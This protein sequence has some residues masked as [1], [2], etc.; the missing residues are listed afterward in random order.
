M[1]LRNVL[2]LGLSLGIGCSAFAADPPK[3]A[4]KKKEMPTFLTVEDAGPDYKIQGEYGAAEAGKA[5]FGVQVIALA[6]DRFRA[7]VYPGGLPGAGWGGDKSTKTEIDGKRAGDMVEFDGKGWRA[8]IGADGSSIKLTGQNGEATEL[9]KVMRQSPTMGAKPPEGAK[10]LYASPDDVQKWNNGHAEARGL[11]AAGAVS[12][13]K[14]KDCTLHVEFLLPFRPA[15][16]GQERGNSGVYLQDRYECQVLDSFGLKGENNEC[17]GF[18]QQFA[19]SVNM[20]LPPLQWQTYDIDF[21]AAK[22]DEQGNKTAKAVAT[23]RHNGVVV[24]DH[25]ELAKPT[26]GGGLSGKDTAAPGPIQLQ[27]HGNPVFYR[28]IWIVEK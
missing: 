16:R 10:V 8:E 15:A 18:Y 1:K 19:P 14:F 28:N 21:T 9:P 27:G 12:K 26:P 13:D 24:Q 3:P 23:V 7:V 11:L 5:K 22:F 2:A 6:D 25:V 20:C 17:A 4:E